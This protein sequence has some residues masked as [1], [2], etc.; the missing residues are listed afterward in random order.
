MADRR[1]FLMHTVVDHF[2]L[3]GQRVD[4]PPIPVTEAKA[5]ELAAFRARVG[6]TSPVTV[7]EVIADGQRMVRPPSRATRTPKPTPSRAMPPP[8]LT[9]R[10]RERYALMYALGL[11]ARCGERPD[12]RFD[13]M[14][15]RGLH[16]CAALDVD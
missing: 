11:C 16:N 2:L 7:E 1:R 3:G 10:Q 4:G 6:R 12:P 8:A 5:R 9:Q 13:W 14:G 15:G